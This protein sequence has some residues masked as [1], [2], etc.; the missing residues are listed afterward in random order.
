MSVVVLALGLVLGLRAPARFL[1]SPEP[2]RELE[3]LGGVLVVAGLMTCIVG[4]V[5]ARRTGALR[6]VWNSPA[7]LLGRPDRKRLLERIR[8]DAGVPPADEEAA[9]ALAEQVVSQGALVPPHLGL[10]VYF[11]GNSLLVSS[12]L[13]RWFLAV[14]L[15]LFAVALPLLVRDSRRAHVWLGHHRPGER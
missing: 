7:A 15:V 12:P 3:V 4:A 1:D 11:V 6:L 2:P 13:G 8:A 10:A 14:A 5:R 9:V